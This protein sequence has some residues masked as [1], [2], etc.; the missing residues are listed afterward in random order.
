M[1]CYFCIVGDADLPFDLL[2]RAEI[3][4]DLFTT[5]RFISSQLALK[6]LQIY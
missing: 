6:V 1:C 5:H 3:F 2:H 4:S